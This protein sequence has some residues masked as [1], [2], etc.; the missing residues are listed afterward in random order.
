MRRASGVGMFICATAGAAAVAVFAK[1]PVAGLAK[2]RLAS[3]LGVHGAARLQ[4]H[5]TLQAL[6]TARA[7]ALGPVSLWCAPDTSHR[8]FRALRLRCALP[9]QEQQGATLGERM[10]TAFRR[11]LSSRPLLLIGTDCPTLTADHLRAAGTALQTVDAAF[12]PA[13]DG[14]YVLIGLR[15]LHPALFRDIPWGTSLVMQQT[16]WRLERLKWSWWE[17]EALHDVDTVGD[18]EYLP[19]DLRHCVMARADFETTPGTLSSADEHFTHNTP[20]ND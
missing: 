5:L 16:R 8:F 11:H 6:T 7:A 20:S 14:G 2:T 3:A 19:Q 4:R 12:Y 17:G 15:R 9:C 10:A 13:V 1:A 18:L